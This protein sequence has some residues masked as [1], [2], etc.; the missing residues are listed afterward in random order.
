VTDVLQLTADVSLQAAADG[1]KAV[2]ILAY[3]GDIMSPAGFGPTVIALDGLKL[4]GQI[5]LLADHASDVANILGPGM[6]TVE[7]GN[8]IVRGSIVDAGPAASKV[9]QLARSGFKFQAS[10][11]MSVES[12]RSLRAGEEAAVNGRIVKAGPR[13]LTIVES[14]ALREVSILA[15]AADPA[16]SVAIAA[17][18]RK[19]MPETATTVTDA[20]EEKQ[21]L[22][23]L[24]T[25][26]L[27]CAR[28]TPAAADM[29]DDLLTAAME[30]IK[31]SPEAFELSILKARPISTIH[32]PYR[33][34]AT[35]DRDVLCASLLLRTGNES[36]AVKA[37]GEQTVETAHRSRVTS[38][39]DLA[40]RALQLGGRDPGD[41]ASTDEMLR[42]A[43]SLQDLPNI[44]AQTTGRV[45]VQAYQATTSTWTPFAF[46]AN[47]QDFKPQMGI[48]PASIEALSPLGPG[49]EIKHSKLL[50]E[51]TYPWQLGTFARMLGITRTTMIN[52][53]L[54]FLAMIGPM[55]G[56]AAGRSL[57]DLIFSVVMGG[58]AAGFFSAANNNLLTTTSALSTTSL[59]AGISLMRKQLDNQGMNIFVEP[60]VL[61]VPPELEM[62]GKALLNSALVGRTDNQPTGNPLVNILPA[63]QVTEPRLS[64]SNITGYST[65]AWYLFS[66]PLSRPVT[67][68][69]LRGKESPTIEIAQGEFNTLGISMRVYF[70][71][72]A[73]L[74]D[75]RAAVKALGT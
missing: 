28:E 24:S 6:A 41:F 50:E 8:L 7:G 27:R 14:G 18:G 57:S 10:V 68:G 12:R 39:V 4:A 2:E 52:D 37:Y 60:A 71:Y 46:V 62:T 16:T 47:A 38:L 72:A 54:G 74:S 61:A 32:R 75:P 11:G 40:G 35:V 17:S 21:R 59:G 1:A 25:V 9:L 63:G 23:A 30:D 48:R 53:D 3:S 15:V 70:D 29:I 31:T 73:A 26:A 51:A 13:G 45:L 56:I 20:A 69:F 66:T 19:V 33:G 34:S 55:M 58:Q 22:K 43:F 42:A 64:N 65:T 36:L 44:L 5:P 49:G 67:V